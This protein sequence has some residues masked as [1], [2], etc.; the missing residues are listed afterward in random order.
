MGESFYR[1]MSEPLFHLL[2]LFSLR[3]Y[4]LGTIGFFSNHNGFS[5]ENISLLPPKTATSLFE[6]HFLISMSGFLLQPGFYGNSLSGLAVFSALGVGSQGN[7]GQFSL[8][9]P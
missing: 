4:L 6:G 1:W 2:E 7:T 9:F 8:C 3:I 5:S